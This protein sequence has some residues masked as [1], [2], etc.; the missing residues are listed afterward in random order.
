MVK[1]VASHSEPITF[2]KLM[3]LEDERAYTRLEA[4]KEEEVE[5]MPKVLDMK[6]LKQVLYEFED[7]ISFL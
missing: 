1:I 7:T 5:L 2:E 4:G 6:I 3:G